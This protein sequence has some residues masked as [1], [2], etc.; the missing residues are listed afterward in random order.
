M[1]D[2]L[3]SADI[4]VDDA[5]A[6]LRQLERSI[7]LPAPRASW[8]Q[9]WD[10][11]GFQ[12]YWCRVS[13]NLATAPTRLQV[14]S[15][16]G[17]P[18]PDVAHPGIGAI[19]RSQAGRPVKTHSTPV[20]VADIDAIADRLAR[21]GVPF[22]IDPPD[23]LMPFPRL[24]AGRHDPKQPGLYVPSADGGLYLELVPTAALQLPAD[25]VLAADPDLQAGD[26]L[27]RVERKSFLTSDL[28]HI[29]ATLKRNFDWEPREVRTG[30]AGRSAIFGF[31]LAHSA[32]IE[33]VEPAS[34]SAEGAVLHA[35]GQGPYLITLSVRDID[36]MESRLAA[37]GV[38][39]YG[40]GE[41]AGH[42]YIDVSSAET[43]KAPIRLVDWREW[44]QTERG[45]TSQQPAV[46][47][48]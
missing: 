43:G 13:P 15:P 19:H 27:V 42:R 8:G 18:S 37:S 36:E 26:M 45:G 24:W 16:K 5:T 31:T 12:A 30:P 33:V 7:L 34:G 47:G 46:R 29:L 32:D 40:R 39:V 11:W 2:L 10:G 35:W 1:Y 44:N 17:E 20:G 25:T 6:V 48:K 3:M 38:G 9:A 4:F 41:Q 21:K 14:I 23:A 28:D 22:R